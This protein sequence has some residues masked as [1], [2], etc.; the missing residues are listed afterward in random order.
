MRAYRLLHSL[1]FWFLLLLLLFIAHSFMFQVSVAYGASDE[2]LVGCRFT[3]I[4]F[5]LTMKQ[6][7]QHENILIILYSFFGSFC[8]SAPTHAIY[9]L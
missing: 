8:C 3:S 7:A 5:Q 1:R 9:L 2:L 4:P 6:A